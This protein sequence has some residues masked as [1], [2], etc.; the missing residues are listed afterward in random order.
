M[1]GENTFATLNGLF[2]TVYADK[3]LDLVPD[4]AILQ[5]LVEFSSADKETGNFYAQPVNL[6]QEAG[7]TY[8]GEAGI[9][10]SLKN[11]RNGTMKEAQVSGS[12]LI[13]RAQL[14]YGALSRASTKGAKAFKRASAWKVEDMNNAMRKR[15]EIGMLYGRAGLG[16]VSAYSSNV[17]TLSDATWAGGIWAGAEG[18]TL[19]VYQNDGTSVRLASIIITAVNSDLKTLTCKMASDGTSNLSTAP[20][21]G[22]LLYYEGAYNSGWKEMAGLQK[23]ISNSS[24][25]F[26]ID[27]STYSLWKGTT[28]SSVGQISHGK[29]QD[30]VARA[31]NKGLMEKALVLVSPKAWGVLNADQSALRVFDGSY[32]SKK[33]ENGAEALCFYASNGQLEVRSHPMVKDGD[34]FIVPTE[35]VL[36][37]GSVDLSF[38]VP[39]MDQEFFSLVPN[40]NAVELQCMAD[41][42]IFLEKPS[43]AVYL[44][45]ITYA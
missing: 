14:S 3:L 37:L 21:V 6:A 5:K 23:I 12:E 19:D 33:V 17:I 4:Y 43:H 15:L 44:S 8:V 34:A 40:T 28:V 16:V 11:A 9:I 45:G 29:I 36:R 26:N 35:S 32:S 18:T 30:A 20:Q 25:L 1:A 13:L 31:V 24:T 27:A 7:F 41:Q 38:G 2:K 39:G 42:A 22:D 10:A